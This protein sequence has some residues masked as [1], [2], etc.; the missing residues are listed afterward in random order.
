MLDIYN[1]QT[2]LGTSDSCFSHLT[3]VNSIFSKMECDCSVIEDTLGSSTGITESN[4]M[5]YMG[6]VEQKTNE[7]LTIQAFLNSKV[8]SQPAVPSC[9]FI[10]TFLLYI[11]CFLFFLLSQDL[12]KDYN[13]K[14]LAK[15]LLG[16]NP[17]LLK[18]NISIQPAVNKWAFYLFILSLYIRLNTLSCRLMSVVCVGW[19]PQY[20]LRCRRVTRHRWRRTATFTGGTSQTN[21]KQG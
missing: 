5:S 21:N 2:V 8:A 20:G 17:E 19:T 9:L 1:T 3:G 6:L 18:Q 14:D 4:I 10:R 16:Q 12:E 11:M 13:P 15:F 7:L